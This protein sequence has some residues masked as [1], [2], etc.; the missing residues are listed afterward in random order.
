[1]LLE[2]FED[3]YYILEK[4]FNLFIEQQKKDGYQVQILLNPYDLQKK[5]ESKY[6]YVRFWKDTGSSRIYKIDC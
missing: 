4:Y 1:M 3:A 2:S 5:K 6:F